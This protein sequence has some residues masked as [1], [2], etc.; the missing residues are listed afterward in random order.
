MDVNGDDSVTAG[1]VLSVI[2]CINQRAPVANAGEG[3]AVSPVVVDNPSLFVEAV[4]GQVIPFQPQLLFDAQPDFSG[5]E[6]SRRVQGIV[7]AVSAE[8]EG[9]LTYKLI[10]TDGQP[11]LAAGDRQNGRRQVLAPMGVPR[12]Q[13]D[14]MFDDPMSS[15]RF[16]EL[17]EL[18][19][20]L[21]MDVAGDRAQ[22]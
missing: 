13:E 10:L 16:G 2:Y 11:T 17:E 14:T 1:D 6:Q 7:R 4:P 8:V 18:L 15:P 12:L 5:Q 3:E 22:I 19:D 20:L 9:Q 21:A